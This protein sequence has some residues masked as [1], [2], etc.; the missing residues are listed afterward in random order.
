MSMIRNKYLALIGAGL[1]FT[2][3][4]CSDGYEPE[5]VELVSLDFVFSRTDSLGTNAVK[6]LNIQNCRTGII[7]SE[8][9]TWMQL[10]MMQ[11]LLMLQIR[12]YINW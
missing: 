11:F 12:M 2:A 9:I 10:L 6:F 1:L 5:P 4:S 3:V 7:V 8:V